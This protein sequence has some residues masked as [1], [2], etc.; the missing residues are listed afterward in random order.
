MLSHI[1]GAV[2]LVFVHMLGEGLSR[3]ILVQFL[4]IF[5]NTKMLESS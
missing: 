5:G 1:I 3:K 4:V 2:I